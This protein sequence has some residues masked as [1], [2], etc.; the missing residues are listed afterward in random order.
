VA[1]SDPVQRRLL[2]DLANDPL[3][4]QIAIWRGQ[5]GSFHLTMLVTQNKWAGFPGH[6]P[7]EILPVKLSRC[8]RFTQPPSGSLE[9]SLSPAPQQADR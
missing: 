9:P 1:C 3:P 8:S 2:H 4:S 6:P 5:T 7:Q